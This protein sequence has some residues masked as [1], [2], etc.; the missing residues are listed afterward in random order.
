MLH[1]IVEPY[2]GAGRRKHLVHR[3]GS[4]PDTD[5]R[6]PVIQADE[7]DKAEPVGMWGYMRRPPVQFAASGVVGSDHALKILGFAGMRDRQRLDGEAVFKR[8]GRN[9]ETAD[10]SKRGRGRTWHGNEDSIGLLRSKA[11]RVGALEFSRAS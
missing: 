11:P 1:P 3:V 6:F 4:I 9:A 2:Y 8:R 10:N 7:V 5:R